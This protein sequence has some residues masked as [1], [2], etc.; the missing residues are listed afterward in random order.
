MLTGRITKL[1]V[2]HINNPQV[3]SL[4]LWYPLR[5]INN[6]LLRMIRLTSVKIMMSQTLKMGG[7]RRKEFKRKNSLLLGRKVRR[8]NEQQ[9]HLFQAAAQVNPA[10]APVLAQ[11]VTH[12]LVNS[13]FPAHCCIN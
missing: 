7:K 2:C 1:T 10:L 4:S 9:Y 5:M 11:A 3:Y 12:L 8:S 6:T 13:I